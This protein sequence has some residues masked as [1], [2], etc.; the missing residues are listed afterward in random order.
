MALIKIEEVSKNARI[1]IWR[2]T[3]DIEFF[4]DRLPKGYLTGYHSERFSENR[5]KEFLASRFLLQEMLNDNEAF[6]NVSENGS[7]YIAGGPSI[8]VSHSMEMV[9]AMVGENVAVGI[10][11]EAVS[12]R[13]KKVMHK[14]IN[15]RERKLLGKNPELWKI[16][17]CWSAKESIYKMT[18]QRGL[19]FSDD[20]MLELPQTASAENFEAIVNK[21]GEKKRLTVSFEQH[22]GFIL[23]YCF[24]NPN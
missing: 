12:D 1:G 24:D 4:K 23:T 15:E 11:I 21:N 6:I 8:S 22:N 7:L 3:E 19:S 2:A 13:V 17:L 20:M 5:K 9:A 18:G 10:D 14:F 16:T